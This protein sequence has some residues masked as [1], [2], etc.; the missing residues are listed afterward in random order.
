[1]IL[2]TIKLLME[3]YGTGLLLC[4]DGETR[5]FKAFLQPVTSKSWQNME[6][7]FGGLG[8]IP[9]GQYLYL[10][11]PEVLLAAGDELQAGAQSY[12]VRKAEAL[13][14]GDRPLYLWALCVRK[15]GDDPWNV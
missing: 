14:L 10:G 9:R 12:I 15:G 5:E 1:M 6:R 2:Q 13:S 4:R 11:P 7:L 8:E 3:H